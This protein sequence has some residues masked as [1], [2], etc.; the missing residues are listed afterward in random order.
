MTTLLF[1]LGLMLIV[2][3]AMAVGVMFG[4]EPIKGSCGGMGAVGIDSACEICGGDT[5][6]CEESSQ[7]GGVGYAGGDR[8]DDQRKS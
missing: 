8:S 2:V 3:A 6:K 1:A 7:T 5:R 4:R